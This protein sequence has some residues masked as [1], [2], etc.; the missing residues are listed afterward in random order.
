MSPLY[1]SFNY[2]F[3]EGDGT[4]RIVT[5]G[6]VLNLDV[7]RQNSYNGGTTWTD[8]SGRGNTGALVNTPTYSSA[9]GGSF[10]FNGTN[11]YIT[12][13]T[14]TSL[15]IT[16]S[17]TVSSWVNVT[18]FPTSGNVGTIYEKGFDGIYEQTFFRFT[19]STLS[20]G[21]YSTSGNITYSADYTFGSSILTNN[22]YNV[23]GQYDGTALKIYLNGNLVSQFSYNLSLFSSSSPV[24]IGAAFISS[25]YQRFFNGKISTTQVYNRALSAAEISQNYNALKSRY[26]LT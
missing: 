20:F 23:V 5:N 10:N 6:L 4:P 18:S 3:G 19:I 2:S 13:G 21:L 11:T 16:S 12:L 1:S 25:S 14:P 7:G 17:I 26:G 8:L 24:S 15:N 22:W 9:N